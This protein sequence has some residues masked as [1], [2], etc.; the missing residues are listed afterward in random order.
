M[1][2]LL[3]KGAANQSTSKNLDDTQGIIGETPNDTHKAYLK[4]KHQ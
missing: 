2:Y 4:K 1:G 3:S